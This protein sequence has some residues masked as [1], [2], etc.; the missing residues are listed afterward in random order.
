M[1]LPDTLAWLRVGWDWLN[2]TGQRKR[3]KLAK[4]YGEAL[5]LSLRR[6]LLAS[7]PSALVEMASTQS[8][9]WPKLREGEKEEIAHRLEEMRLPQPD[10]FG[11]LI[12]S[13]M[14]RLARGENLPVCRRDAQGRRIP[15]AENSE[16][17]DET[18]T[19]SMGTLSPA[20]AGSIAE[21]ARATGRTPEEVAK[22]TF[23][24]AA[25]AIV[26]AKEPEALPTREDVASKAVWASLAMVERNPMEAARIVAG[27]EHALVLMLKNAVATA[28]T[29]MR[30]GSEIRQA[31]EEAAGSLD[32][33]LPKAGKAPLSPARKGALRDIMTEVKRCRG[34]AKNPKDAAAF[35]E[36]E[37]S[38][39]AL[40]ARWKRGLAA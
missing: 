30:K 7:D 24:N 13:G 22:E 5:P 32:A 20:T 34:N 27:G 26:A 25:R 4:E 38:L 17:R 40:E 35:G 31:F 23:L 9:A 14:D 37:T 18:R 1:A 28:A 33:W 29:K 15:H 6:L 21:K 10:F 19:I 36:I 12:R 16:N 11:L 8:E 3:V 39:V 2:K